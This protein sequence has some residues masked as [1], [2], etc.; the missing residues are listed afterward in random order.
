MG[1]RARARARQGRQAEP[2][3]PAPT[4][5]YTSPEGDILVL[6]GSLSAATRREYEERIAGG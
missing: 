1:K 5:D 4:T 6:R 3:G 2:L